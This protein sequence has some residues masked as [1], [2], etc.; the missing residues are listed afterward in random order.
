VVEQSEV[1]MQLSLVSDMG[2]H[3]AVKNFFARMLTVR[4]SLT[5]T[6]RVQTK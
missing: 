3:R 5:P 2:R 6:N 1:L 4:N